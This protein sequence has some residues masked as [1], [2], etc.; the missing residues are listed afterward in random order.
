VNSPKEKHLDG[1]GV[2]DPSWLFF[3][4]SSKTFTIVVVLWL[5]E[6]L[7]EQIESGGWLVVDMS[8][9][10]ATPFTSLVLTSSLVTSIAGD[11]FAV[12]DSQSEIL[13]ACES[14]DW[15]HH[16]YQASDRSSERRLFLV[17]SF[18]FLVLLLHT[19]NTDPLLND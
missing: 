13:S 2:C 5:G 1:A 7:P 11:Q 10:A 9:R 3:R 14:T 19:H 15:F 18:R 17:V 12:A 6:P 16:R 8:Q 4:Y